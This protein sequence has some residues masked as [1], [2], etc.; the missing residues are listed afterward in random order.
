M[1]GIRDGSAG[2]LQNDRT[3]RLIVWTVWAGMIALLLWSYIPISSPIPLAEDWYTVPLITGQQVPL[4]AW[5]WEQ[6]NEHRMPVARLLLLGA[7]KA[8]GGD[9]RAGGLLNLALLAAGA[10]GLILFVRHLRGG[11]TDAGDAFLPLTLLHFGHSVDVLFP[12][13]ITFV[14]SLALIMLVGCTLFLPTSLTSRSAAAIGGGA[15]LL[16]PLSGFIGLLFVPALAAYVFYAGWSCWTGARGWPRLRPTGAWLMA[17]SILTVALAGIYFVGYQHPWWNPPNPGIIPS[18]KVVLQVLSLG[19]G[20]APYFWFKPAIIAAM[21][22]LPASFLE[23]VRRVDWSAPLRDYRLG[24]ALFFAA[25]IAFAA[26][27]G[28]GRAG[29]VPTAG[30]PLRYVSLVL[31]AFLAAY[32]TWVLSPSSIGPAV[33]RGLAL[34]ML[35]LLPVNTIAGHRQFADWYHDGMMKLQR[36]LDAGVPIEELAARHGKFLVH[37]WKSEEVARHMHMLHDAGIPPFDRA[38]THSDGR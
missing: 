26:A 37:W 7:L 27:A 25:A 13:Q 19:F 3:A 32:F 2:P 4:G 33:G 36:D 14:L 1:D 30:I 23:A 10:A 12:F 20:A 35:I 16:L 6:N 17:A 18:T 15:L 5:L 29:Y 31:P 8:S 28:W 38:S 21:V 22:F 34:V 24:A 11:R 9:Y